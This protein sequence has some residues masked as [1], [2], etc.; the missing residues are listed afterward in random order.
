MQRW[1]LGVALT[2]L[3]VVAT[4]EA[5]TLATPD[6]KN[7]VEPPPPSTTLAPPKRAEAGSPAEA[8]VDESFTYDLIVT[9]VPVRDAPTMRAS[10]SGEVRHGQRI[11]LQCW[12]IGEPV[13][14]GYPDS[15]YDDDKQYDSNVWW[16]VTELGVE[17]Y[18]SDVWVGRTDGDR[19]GV[20]PCSDT[21]TS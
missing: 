19:L 18:V 4:I 2:V 16:Y 3:V 5:V 6:Q 14:N 13:T 8:T 12:T 10:A 9:G 11:T 15:T 7:E 17:G 20:D 1:F 21:A